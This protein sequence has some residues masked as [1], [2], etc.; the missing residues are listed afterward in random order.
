MIYTMKTFVFFLLSLSLATAYQL[1]SAFSGSKVA[2]P[3]LK[4]SEALRMSAT[5]DLSEEQ[6]FSAPT[7]E[8]LL[9]RAAKGQV[10]ITDKQP[11]KF[12]KS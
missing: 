4:S 9:L 10:S 6:V 3:S 1:N 5:M 12:Q 7:D 2:L 11:F 8:P